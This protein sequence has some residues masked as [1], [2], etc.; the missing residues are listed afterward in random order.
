[1]VMGHILRPGHH[2]E[3]SHTISTDMRFIEHL[4]PTVDVM[5]KSALVA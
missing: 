4:A 5:S 1:M 2:S 3:R